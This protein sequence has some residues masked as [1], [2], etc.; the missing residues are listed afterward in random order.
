MKTDK[1]FDCVKMMRDIR[2]KI[3]T[4]IINMDSV[5]IMEYFRKKS[6]EFESKYGQPVTSAHT[7]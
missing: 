2:D 5:Q 7:P 6:L 4:E 3:N 1:D